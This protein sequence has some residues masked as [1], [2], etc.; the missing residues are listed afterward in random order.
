MASREIRLIIPG[1][2]YE[3]LR[4]VEDKTGIK[5]EDLIM[6]ALVKVIEEFGGG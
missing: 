5:M 6:R 2:V 1:N 3:A 4:K